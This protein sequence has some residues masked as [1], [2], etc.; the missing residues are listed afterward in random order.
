M[1]NWQKVF[2]HEHL[3]KAELVKLILENHE[4]N[5]VVIN[6]RDSSYNNFGFHE[7]YVSPDFV[8]QAIKII[9]DDIDFK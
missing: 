2:S 8:L 5:P 3:H 1:N 4:L 6:R 7:V 9:N